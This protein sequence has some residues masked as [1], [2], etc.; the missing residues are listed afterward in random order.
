MTALHVCLPVWL[1]VPADGLGCDLGALKKALAGKGVNARGW[2]LYLD[3]GDPMFD[4]LGKPWID[5]DRPSWSAA[6]AVNWL[7]LLA[8]CEMD[9]LP[10]ARLVRS[11]SRWQVP[12]GLLDNIPPQFLRAAWKACVAPDYAGDDDK[13]VA[14]FIDEEVAP[15]AR[16]YLSHRRAN[17]PDA[18]LLKAGW[19]ALLRRYGEWRLQETI[20]K[21]A[22]SP[23]PAEWP[24][25]VPAVEYDG[26]RFVSLL[27]E[28]ALEAEGALMKHCIGT[29]ADNCRRRMLR[30]YSIRDRK[31]GARVGTLTVEEAAPGLWAIDAIKGHSNN[32][33]DKRVEAAAWSVVRALEEAYARLTATG[34]EM[35]RFRGDAA[36]ARGSHAAGTQAFL[37]PEIC[38]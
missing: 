9:V 34:A 4:A 29:Y 3:Y 28:P 38:F 16:W 5:P 12:G 15:L 26:L 27:S 13:P 21:E 22:H 24:A 18:H 31:T 2:R 17:K 7:K 14:Q 37:E 30:A 8:A 23:A 35:N 36:K 19:P 33:V 6:S 25:F 32:A 10:P 20:R 11:L 1:R